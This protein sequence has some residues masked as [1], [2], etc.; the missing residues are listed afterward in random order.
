MTADEVRVTI[1]YALEACG[2]REEVR[3]RASDPA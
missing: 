1:L 2:M 3:Q